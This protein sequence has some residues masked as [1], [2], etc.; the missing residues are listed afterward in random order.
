M[1]SLTSLR[2]VEE[3]SRQEVDKQWKVRSGMSK[4]WPAHVGRVGRVGERR[5][6]FEVMV[7]GH[8]GVRYKRAKTVGKKQAEGGLS[9]I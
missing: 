6:G 9:G 8:V 7:K 5:E 1:S 2:E 4:F 3:D